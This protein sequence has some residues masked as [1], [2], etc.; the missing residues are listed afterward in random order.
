MGQIRHGCVM[1]VGI[2]RIAEPAVDIE[3]AQV[4][5]RVIPLYLIERPGSLTLS[6]VKLTSV[7]SMVLGEAA[8]T[9]Y[10]AADSGVKSPGEQNRYHY[11]DKA[12]QDFDAPVFPP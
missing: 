12:S 2:P 11:R 8:G 3:R 7:S 4:S 9:E 10:R 1:V 6:L 5:L